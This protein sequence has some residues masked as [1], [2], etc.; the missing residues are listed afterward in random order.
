MP[1]SITSVLS[2]WED[3]EAALRQDGCL[4]LLIVGRGQFRARLTR[5]T[6]H[7]V[8]LLAAE[9]HLSRIAFI[10]VPTGMVLILLPIRSGSA[11]VYGGTG[12]RAGE[13]IAVGSGRHV[14]VRT[15]GH[16][17][18]SAMWLPATQLAVYGSA[19]T[20]APFAVP[21][22]VTSWLPP[23]ADGRHVHK[24]H[25]AAIRMAEIRPRVLL[26]P[27]A[28][29]G[30]EQ[31]L[32]HALIECASAGVAT[33]GGSAARRHQDIMAGFE[34]LLQAHPDHNLRMAEIC[35]ALGISNRQL[36]I[37]CAA[38]LGMSGA[39]YIR[40]R[41]LSLVRSNLRRSDRDAVTVSE[42]ARRYGFRDL[43]RFAAAYRAAFGELP[44]A[45]LQG[46]LGR[47]PAKLRLHRTRQR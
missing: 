25:A 40:L 29:H 35:V 42:I 31:Q 3:F 20:G 23:P 19:L 39:G 43:G 11:P 16:C 27:E 22:G 10:A 34:G 17:H 12:M 45:T 37:L 33:E 2:E 1:G 30:L 4:S 15:G 7:H 8:R 5:L 46:G 36:R 6:L 9:E 24:L 38:H 13:I 14:Y 18:W 44:S 26:D 32:I 41:R 21:V 28:A 47:K